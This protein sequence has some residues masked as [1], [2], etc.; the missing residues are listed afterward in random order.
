MDQD[1]F[2]WTADSYCALF[3]HLA[4]LGIVKKMS[5]PIDSKDF[6]P[7]Y[8]DR[9]D[10]RY[11]EP[12]KDMF[13]QLMEWDGS[14]CLYRWEIVSPYNADDIKQA[15]E[16]LPKHTPHV[17]KN[18]VTDDDTLYVGKSEGCIYGR[19][20]EHLG[21]HRNQ[22]R[23]GLQLS[24]W[25]KP[26]HLRFVLHVTVLQPDCLQRPWVMEIFETA[27]AE[28]HKPLIGIH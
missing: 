22:A 8:R 2:K 10:V 26:M 7:K 18:A 17:V 23:H 21:Y 4:S 12:F 25:A 27:L 15:V 5:F 28:K 16:N 6:D 20:I 13:A 19:I 14:P 9:E 11:A 24:D 3:H 1:L